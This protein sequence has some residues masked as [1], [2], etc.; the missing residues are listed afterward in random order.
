V[1]SALFL[2]TD[3]VED[4]TGYQRPSCQVRQLQEYGLRFFVAAD[5]R[6]RVVRAAIMQSRNMAQ[7]EEPNLVGL[8][9]LGRE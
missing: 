5:G 9:S 2:T 7:P 4:L 8:N 3:E 1:K 6:P